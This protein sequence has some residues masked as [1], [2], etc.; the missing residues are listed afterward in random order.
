MIHAAMAAP[1]SIPNANTMTEIISL[2]ARLSTG[3]VSSSSAVG[4]MGRHESQLPDHLS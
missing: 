2:A 1:A 4:I 3:G